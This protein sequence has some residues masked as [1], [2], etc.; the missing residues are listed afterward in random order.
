MTPHT[1]DVIVAKIDDVIVAKIL[2]FIRF[3]RS[4]LESEQ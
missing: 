4:R 1:D 3:I 2:L